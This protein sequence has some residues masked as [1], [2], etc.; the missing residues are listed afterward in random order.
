MGSEE[1]FSD[2][3]AAK[4]PKEGKDSKSPCDDTSAED[5]R[6]GLSGHRASSLAR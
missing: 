6:Y 2:H 3:T 4:A 1:V 5:W